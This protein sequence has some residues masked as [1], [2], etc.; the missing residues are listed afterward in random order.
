M[1][2]EVDL[3][4]TDEAAAVESVRRA[5]S[6]QGFFYLVGHGVSSEVRERL[7]TDMVR[8]FALPRED[9]LA[10]HCLSNPHNRG[11]TAMGEEKLDPA[12]QTCGDTKEGYYIGSEIPAGHPLAEV[13]LH[14]PNVWPA[15]PNWRAAMEEYSAEMERIG[16]SLLRLIALS[17]NL[18][19]DFFDAD[20]TNPMLFLR[21][22]RYSEQR[23]ELDGEGRGTLA[24]GEHSDYGMLTLLSTDANPGLQIK[25]KEG[26]W[27]D[28]PPR[29]DALVINLGDM[30]ERWTNGVYRS[31]PHR[32]LNT[33]GKE[34]FSAPFFF[35]PNFHAR[36]C[37][38]PS[39]VSPERPQRW[40]ACTSGEHLLNKYAQTQDGFVPPPST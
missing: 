14:G 29:T 38:L 39:C 33:H 34:R 2:P 12:K 35:E 5:C 17:L 25:T 36:V 23:S 10:L 27:L 22:L 13:P 8:L 32:V 26:A 11:W 18:N 24:C 19:A 7:Y 16:R 31:T 21:L 30:L 9:K 1:I 28:V 40:E 37:P 15:L 20:F 4:G 3:S 6:E